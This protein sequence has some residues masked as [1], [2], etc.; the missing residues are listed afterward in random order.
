R[1]SPA[2]PP[3]SDEALSKHLL[4]LREA[5]LAISANLSL[6]ETLKRIVAAAAEL[7]NARYAALGVPDEA[8]ES[9]AEFVTTGLSAEAEARISHRP[10]GQGVLGVILEEGQSL[11]LRDVRQH[12][13]S[14]GFPPHHPVMTSFL[15]VPITYKGKR[16]GNLYLTD[17]REAS[18]FTE[19]DQTLIE[20]LAAH[21]AGAIQNARLHQATLDHSRELEESN[22]ALAA[23]NAVAAAVSRYLD[24]NQVMTEALDQ[25]LAVSGA[26]A[27]EIFL[28]DD[29]SGDMMLALHR[30]AF[31]ETFQMIRRFKRGE[32]LPGQV[33]LTGRPFVSSDLAHDTRYLRRE[34]IEAGFN[35]YACVPLYAKGKV[36]GSLNLAARDPAVFDES[37]LTLLTGIGH[38]I[39]VAVE[40]ARLYQQVA[41]LAVLE[42]RQRIGMDLHDGVI[43]SIY[44]VG[45]TLEYISSQLADGDLAGAR[46]RVT[47]AV[48]ALNTTIRDIRAYILDLR[49]RHFEGDNLI[50]GLER[51][52]AEFKVNTLMTVEFTADPA[53]DQWLTPDARLALFH[54]AQEALSN[55]ARHSRASRLE[56][57]LLE[58]GAEVVL[59]LK[60]NG[61][62]F[63]PA[64]AERRVGHGL[65]NMHDR[66]V[67]LGGELS[68]ESLGGAGAQVCVRLPK[69]AA[70]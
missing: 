47:S 10:R 6:A 43:Q 31:P 45:L 22:R 2:P 8:G 24:L 27:G 32:G 56:V 19:A 16:L 11:R 37:N 63:D 62:G 64:A 1:T 13:R 35:A 67:S 3:V 28:L 38:Q 18:E 15:G 60:D 39:G 23:V 51:L 14:V 49:P 9:L 57:R 30:G 42:E 65:M 54:I 44:A 52:L 58:E 69:R 55:A 26:E 48:E 33:A 41:Q 68:I 20:L 21:A 12:P 4:A 7:V 5:A 59:V 40:N 29:V 61:R 50:V 66:A 17:K 25:V 36:V 70:A 34:V 46:G 53:A